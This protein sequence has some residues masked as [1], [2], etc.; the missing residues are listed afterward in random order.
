MIIRNF[1]NARSVSSKSIGGSA[2]TSAMSWALKQGTARNLR[3]QYFD[4]RD[5]SRNHA[6][7]RTAISSIGR[8][9]IGPGFDLVK[10]PLYGGEGTKRQYKRLL[11][12]Y[13]NIDMIESDVRD[14]SAKHPLSARLYK[15]VGCFRLFGSAWWE[16]RRNG[17]DQPIGSSIID[18]YVHPNIDGKGIFKSPAYLQYKSESSGYTELGYE[19]VIAFM[20]PDFSGPAFATDIESLI[21]YTLSSDIYMLTSIR[22]LFKNMRTPMGIWSV[23]KDADTQVYDTFVEQI[24]ALYQGAKNYGK[25]AITSQG[26]IDYTP[27]AQSMND[28]PWQKGHEMSRDETMAAAGQFVQKVGLESAQGNSLQELRREFWEQTILPITRVL[29]EIMWTEVH[30]RLFGIRGWIPQF[31]PPD[32]TTALQ[33]ASI[34][35]RYIQWGVQSPNEVRVQLNLDEKEELDYHLH[36]SNMIMVGEQGGAED[37]VDASDEEPDPL[38]ENPV[39]PGNTPPERPDDGHESIA[40]LNEFKRFLLNDAKRDKKR[41]RSFKAEHLSKEVV[42]W[43]EQSVDTYGLTKDVV[44]AIIESVMETYKC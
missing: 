31:S 32:F 34:A 7:L 2:Q 13:N 26:D 17:L 30:V 15:T 44:E 19:D 37:P 10:H 38:E 21:E 22:E 27:I 23:D 4:L 18:G 33:D 24:E 5:A 1:G 42:D 29:S 25:S 36:P 40:E 43:I 20:W 16:V 12:F 11:N 39:P 14:I 9:I 28:V 6:Y 8:A 41:H 35:A 3:S